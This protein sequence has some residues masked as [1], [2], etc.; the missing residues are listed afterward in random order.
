MRLRDNKEEK[1]RVIPPTQNN[2]YVCILIH[3]YT[4]YLANI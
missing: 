1:E 2:E 3:N 4:I